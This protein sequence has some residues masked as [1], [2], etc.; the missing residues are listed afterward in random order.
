MSDLLLDLRTASA[1]AE[2]GG[3][4]A[5]LRWLL[6]SRRR[7]PPGW[8]IPSAVIANLGPN[9]DRL[10]TELVGIVRTDRA[11]AVRSSADIEDGERRSFAGQFMT[12]LDVRGVEDVLAAV[13]EV[14]ASAT[15]DGA[16]SYAVGGSDPAPARMSVIVQEQAGARAAGVAFSRNPLT[17]LDEVMI[18]AVRGSG[19]SLVQEGVTPER[20]IHRWGTVVARPDEPILDDAVVVALADE[21][22]AIAAAWGRPVDLEWAWDG[23]DVWWLQVRTI[24]GLEG[25]R[26]FSNRIAREVLPGLIPPLVWS[27]NVPVVNR[28]WV[29]LIEQVIGPSGIRAEDLARQFG[30]RAYFDMTTL[31]RVFDAFGMPRESLELLLGL[32]PGAEPPRFRPGRSA[33]RHVPRLAR[34]LGSLLV[35]R[36]TV[37]AELRS[38]VADFDAVAIEAPEALSDQALLARVDRLMAITERAAYANIVTPLLMGAYH[39]LLERRLRARGIDAASIDPAA[40]RV[41]GRRYDPRDALDALAERIADLPA[42]EREALA[43]GGW[44]ALRERP[45]LAETAAAIE[46]FERRFGHLSPS[47]N[48]FSVPTWGETRD[49]MLTMI[50]EHVPRARRASD[51]WPELSQA[52]SPL[53]RPLLRTIFVRAAAFRVAR[54]A[55]SFIYTRGY[56][57]LRPTFL[58][59]GRRLVDRGLLDGSADIFLL[60]LDEVRAALTGRVTT[61]LR[62]RVAARRREMDEAADLDLPDLIYGEDFVPHRRRNDDA[63]AVLRGVPTSRGNRTGPARIVTSRDGFGRV[64]AGDVVVVPHSDVSWTPLF[65]RAAAIVAESGGMLSHSSIVAR[66]Y[67]IPCVV[68]VTGAC[69][70]IPDGAIVTVDGFSGTVELQP[71]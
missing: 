56:G 44:P 20:W 59:A 53:E 33:V 51:P 5:G 8:V 67:G 23:T 14:A 6:R 18:E 21:T 15:A 31:G 26:I 55:V 19:A 69:A 32:P 11:Y 48:D 9:H 65:A 46:A 61:N 35:Y 16:R 52:L 22:R 49:A 4:A 2:I 29:R 7:V 10:R 62:D 64:K 42:A 25:V 47:G 60:T 68:S 39:R 1:D 40:G 57:L 70:A 58:E 43:A 36:R 30:Y 13:E 17:G 12:R 41:D 27:V 50:V 54:D 45:A 28:A 63:S 24:T 3:K 37:R 66:E 38:L 71:G 34:F